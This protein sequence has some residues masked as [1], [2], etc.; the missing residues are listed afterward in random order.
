VEKAEVLPVL[1]AEVDAIAAIARQ[2]DIDE[3]AALGLTIQQGMIDGINGS[4]KVSKFVVGGRVVAVFGDAD[5]AEM[6]G[7]GVPWMIST[8]HINRH[9][10]AFLQ[11]S[12]LEVADMMTRH[13]ALLNFVDVRNTLAARWLKWVGFQFH[14]ATVYGKRGELFYPFTLQGA[15]HV[16]Q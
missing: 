14:E 13:A 15:A 1:L 2:A 10:K 4:R 7:V 3:F 16:R 8:V 11:A 9:A 12:K 6:P 5:C